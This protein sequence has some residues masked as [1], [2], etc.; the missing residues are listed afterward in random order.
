MKYHK[1]T[2]D[3][4]D[5]LRGIAGPANVST[6]D[7]D[8]DNYAIDEAGA[9][10]PCRPEVVVWAENTETV[11]KV[12]AF[13]SRN[14]IPVTPRGGGTGVSGGC[15]PVLGGIVLSLEKMDRIIKIED[16]NFTA[17][18]EPGVIVNNLN[19][20][21][22]QHKLYYPVHISA[23]TATIGGNVST[24]AGG[25]NAVKYGVTSHQ[26]LG[27]EVVL[28]DG[29]VLNTGGEYI[30]SSTGYNLTQLVIGSEGTLAVV[31][32]IIIRLLP[33]PAATE[34]LYVPFAT[35]QGAVD[36][37]PE[38]LRMDNIPMGLEFFE[39]DTVKVAEKFMEYELPCDDYE[40]FL[41]II[42]EGNSSEAIIENFQLMEKICRRNGAVDFYAPDDAR[43]KRKLIEFREKIGESMKQFGKPDAVDAVV[44]RYKFAEYAKTVK[45]IAAEFNVLVYLAGH[46]GD[47][48]LHF[49]PVFAGNNK[50]EI[51][52]IKDRFLQ[53]IYHACVA[54][55]GTISGE[56]SIGSEKKKYAPIALNDDT[57]SLMKRI[58]E[59]FDPKHILNPGKIF[60]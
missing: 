14:L 17:I 34:M 42:M 31:T 20:V 60:D 18:V 6:K 36:T 47:G 1:L 59:S 23:Q 7:S 45:E 8:R 3:K 51:K 39:R 11:S 15:I 12:L 40:A 27:L 46:A 44:P 38:L 41:L 43:T 54:L 19:E 56:H 25:M 50:E 24:N 10:V 53:R 22:A 4:L 52:E 29:T 48:N 9:A 28:A 16:D 35:L 30:K 49:S 57:I 33:L 32:R 58:K 21:L 2:P 37:V 13:A 5:L 55:G 26:V